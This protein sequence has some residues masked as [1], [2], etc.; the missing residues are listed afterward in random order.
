MEMTADRLDDSHLHEGREAPESF[1][2]AGEAGA[3]EAGARETGARE[4]GA[5]EA[6]SGVATGSWTPAGEVAAPLSEDAVIAAIATVY[7]PEIPVNIYE[8]GLIYAVDLHADGQV[9]VEM[10]LTAPG[11]S[12][13]PGIAGTSARC[14]ADGCRGH[15]LRGG[16]GLGASLG[17]EPDER[18]RAPRAEHVLIEGVRQ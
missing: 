12:E 2:L 5:R 15:Q 9:K 11:L 10:T 13:C 7:D 4:T 1:S 3:R 14:R 6:G 8:L 17:S 18:R 16:D